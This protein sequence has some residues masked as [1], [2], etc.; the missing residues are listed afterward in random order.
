MADRWVGQAQSRVTGVEFSVSDGDTTALCELSF[1]TDLAAVG[2]AGVSCQ[3]LYS[4]AGAGAASVMVTATNLGSKQTAWTFYTEI[5]ARRSS[6]TWSVAL[7]ESGRFGVLYT[8][9][10]A[11]RRQRGL[12]SWRES[13]T[14][15][16]H[17]P[18][19]Q[20]IFTMRQGNV[21]YLVI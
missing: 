18:T 8:I 17:Q 1:H 6:Y 16:H 14:A 5:G 19:G 15:S 4:A 11:W 12:P 20:A 7:R 3:Q 13:L 10:F 9:Y 21:K 2:W